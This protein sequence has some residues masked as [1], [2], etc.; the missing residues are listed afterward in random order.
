[1]LLAEEE[2]SVQIRK[3]DCIEVDNVDFAKA[4]QDQVLQKF[5]ADSS[6]TNHK[7]AGLPRHDQ[8]EC[9]KGIRMR[10]VWGQRFEASRLIE[11]I[12]G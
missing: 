5:A 4:G 7:H 11:T 9:D 12:G 2:L 8:L 3:I 6:S 1:M 10:I